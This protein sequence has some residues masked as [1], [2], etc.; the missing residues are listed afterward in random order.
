LTLVSVNAMIHVNA[1]KT[2]QRKFARSSLI[3]AI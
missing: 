1:S 2:K 3:S